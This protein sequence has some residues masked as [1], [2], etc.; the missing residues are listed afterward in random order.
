LEI[1]LEIGSITLDKE[2]LK[3]LRERGVK[4]ALGSASRNAPLI[5]EKLGIGY[6]FD[7]V[8]DGNRVIRAK[9]DPEVFLI[10]AQELLVEPARC[11]VFED[12][13][14]GLQAA[15]AAGMHAIGIGDPR[16]LRSAHATVPGLHAFDIDSLF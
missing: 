1:L 14:A 15:R 6:L 3:Q 13:E 9:P 16:V 10:G 2:C 12:A 4:T 11:V 5:L 8:I 7:A